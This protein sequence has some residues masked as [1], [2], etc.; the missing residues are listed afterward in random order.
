MM[1]SMKEKKPI[2][3]DGEVK[4]EELDKVAGGIIDFTM[5]PFYCTN[6]NETSYW[7]AYIVG[8]RTKGMQCKFCK[9]HQTYKVES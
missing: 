7:P 5:V 8:S 2:K 4:D 9:C 1:I 6:C 3:S